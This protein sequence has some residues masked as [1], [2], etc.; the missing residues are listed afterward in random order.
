MRLHNNRQ[1]GF[2]LIELMVVITILAVLTTLGWSSY[3]S[4]ARKGHRTEGMIALAQ[5]AQQMERFYSRNGRYTGN[6]NDLDGIAQSEHGRYNI[7]IGF[8]AATPNQ[9]LLT[10]TAIGPQAQDT[11]CA[12]FTLDHLGERLAYDDSAVLATR[13]CWSQ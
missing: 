4:Q 5:K 9:Y 10:A 6:I 12:S 2:T 13:N 8:N 7:V 11:A 3:Q 1:H